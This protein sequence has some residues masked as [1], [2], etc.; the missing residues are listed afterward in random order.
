MHTSAYVGKSLAGSYTGQVYHPE[1]YLQTPKG[2]A[3]ESLL[4]P[5]NMEDNF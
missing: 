3:A 1:C 4:S 5:D 2:E